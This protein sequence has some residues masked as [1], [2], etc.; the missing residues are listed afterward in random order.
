VY[1]ATTLDLAS[2]RLLGG[3]SMDDHMRTELVSAALEAAV[4]AG[5][6]VRMDEVIF[7]SDR[8]SQ[9]TSGDFAEVCEQLPG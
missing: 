5:G 8:G 3:W 1:L 7:H 9:Y 2:R 4:A 6:R